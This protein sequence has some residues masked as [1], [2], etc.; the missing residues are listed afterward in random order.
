MRIALNSKTSGGF[1]T[2][3]LNNR[4]H[5]VTHMVSIVGDSVMN[6]LFLP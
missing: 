4:E 5:I 1:K 2:K 6:G 3:K